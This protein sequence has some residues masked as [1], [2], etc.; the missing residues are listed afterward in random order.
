MRPSFATALSGLTIRHV[1]LIL[2]GVAGGVLPLGLASARLARAAQAAQAASNPP[3]VYQSGAQGTGYYV[4]TP[5]RPG[6]APLAPARRAPAAGNRPR[7]VGP[8]ARNWATGSRVPLSRPW[9][10]AID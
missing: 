10:H 1:A 8:G 2:F 3:Y 9:L 5:S 4:S 7:T 6:P